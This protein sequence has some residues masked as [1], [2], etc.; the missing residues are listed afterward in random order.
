MRDEFAEECAGEHVQR[1]EQTERIQ[2]IT[3]DST[4][5]RC[6]T[7]RNMDIE[8]RT[9]NVRH[10]SM[11]KQTHDTNAD[12]TNT[13]K[14]GI[15]NKPQRDGKAILLCNRAELSQYGKMLTG[16]SGPVA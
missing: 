11:S 16:A 8:A 3:I 6:L 9:D 14:A 7:K 1:S 4:N 13:P 2:G 5:R 12:Y 15:R 10:S